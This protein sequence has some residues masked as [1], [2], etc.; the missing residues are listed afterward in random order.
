MLERGAVP[1][2]FVLGNRWRDWPDLET[3]DESAI[4]AT[5]WRFVG[6]RNSWVAQ[7]Y[8]RLRDALVARGHAVRVSESPVAGTISIVHRDDLNGFSSASHGTFLV[9]VRADRAPVVACDFAIVQNGLHSRPNERFIPLWP[10]PGLAPRETARAH[11]IRRIVYQGRVGSVPR[12][13]AELQSGGE[14]AM[15]GVSL[16]IRDSG[17]HDYRNA[18]LV[19]AA[20][21]DA[22]V[23]LAVK[24][25]TKIYNG[26]LAGVPVLAAPEP[27]YR[28][29]RRTPLDFLAVQ[30][31]RDVIA[32]VDLL[33][34]SPALYDAM[35]RNGRRRGAMFRVE[36][37]R[38]RWLAFIEKEAVPAFDRAGASLQGRRAW[39]VRSML[40]QKV[41]SRV[42]RVRLAVGRWWIRSSW[43]PIADL[44]AD[45]CR[46]SWNFASMGGAEPDLRT[47][48]TNV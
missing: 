43:A 42:W 30:G 17:W 10:Q 9:V 11:R 32:A 21:E 27:A 37:T 41:L 6:G 39:F 44:P 26:W 15:R 48:T 36:M 13:F 23:M 29:L 46:R 16:D 40:R 31:S 5:P 33:N 24:P 20:R 47:R 14:L 45:Q 35:V 19:I 4:S 28:E 8:L 18:D 2:T 22:G 38:R 7:G 3:L 34:A 25:G 1:I 12:W